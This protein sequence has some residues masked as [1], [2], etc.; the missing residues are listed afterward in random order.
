MWK[1][2]LAICKKDFR[3]EIRTRYSINGLIMFIIVTISIIKFSLGEEK[4]SNELHAGLL[5]IIIFFSNSSGLSR[6]FVAEE[7]RGTSFV[8]KLTA[9]PKSVFLGKLIFNTTL[10]FVINL[11]VVLL[12]LVTMDV[13]IASFG[14]FMLIIV[15]GNFGLSSVMTIIAALISKSNSKGS[16][17]PVLSFPLLLPLLLSTIN[18]TWLSFEGSGITE[19]LSEVQIIV[20]YTIVIITA[21]FLLFDIIW[22]E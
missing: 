6:V 21:S 8:L 10:S 3:S 11:F 7:D 5:W 22:N 1:Q 17:Y 4:L 9:S 15:L 2:A 16:L 12:F 13:K 19:L 20:S 18:G 14:P